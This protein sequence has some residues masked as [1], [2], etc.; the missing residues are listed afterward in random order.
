MGGQTFLSKC[1]GELF[2][3]G[4]LMIRSYQGKGGKFINAFPS[5]LNT[6]NLKIFPNYGGIFTWRWS[7]CSYRIME[8][9]ILEVNSQAWVC[10]HAWN[11]H[12]KISKPHK[13]YVHVTCCINKLFLNFVWLICLYY[14]ILAYYLF[15]VRFIQTFFSSQIQKYCPLF[16]SICFCFFLLGQQGY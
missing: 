16:S 2:Y 9:F 6:V 4:G 5:N 8:E 15:T 1:T 7:P 14:C 3:M 10:K 12:V 13:T 11:R